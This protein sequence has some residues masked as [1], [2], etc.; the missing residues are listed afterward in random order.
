MSSTS[1]PS[2]GLLA[3]AP[4][5]SVIP[6]Q[7]TAPPPPQLLTD[8]FELDGVGDQRLGGDLTLVRARV[9]LLRELDHQSPVVPG[10]VSRHLEARVVGV[11]VRAGRQNVQVTGPDPRYLATGNG[12][13]P[14]VRAVR[15]AQVRTLR[16]GQEVSSVKSALVSSVRSAQ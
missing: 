9:R 16:S 11:R 6:R 14:L 4:L 13:S 3:S 5:P 8:D 2:L 7:S 12:R 1:S 10:G 15:S